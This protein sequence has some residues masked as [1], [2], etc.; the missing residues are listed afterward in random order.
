MQVKVIQSVGKENTKHKPEDSLLSGRGSGGASARRHRSSVQKGDRTG[1]RKVW[2]KS[3]PHSHK[4]FFIQK[5]VDWAPFA[6]KSRTLSLIA[7]TSKFNRYRITI[8]N[9]GGAVPGD[10]CRFKDAPSRT[11]SGKLGPW[12]RGSW[13][14][15]WPWKPACLVCDSMECPCSYIVQKHGKGEE[16]LRESRFVVT[17]NKELYGVQ[18]LT[19]EVF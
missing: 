11:N 18:V 4:S 10:W 3:I 8:K 19:G 5:F 2:Y 1:P 7:T 17:Y 12:S 16:N 14:S 9:S 13:W 6:R 15:S